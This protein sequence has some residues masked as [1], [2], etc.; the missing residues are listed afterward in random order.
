MKNALII[1][2]SLFFALAILF[3][4]NA[5]TNDQ[6]EGSPIGDTQ[7]TNLEKKNTTTEVNPEISAANLPLI[8]AKSS[9]EKYVDWGSKPMESE[10]GPADP[11]TMPFMMC[12]GPAFLDG[13]LKASSTLAA[14]G[15]IKYSASQ[16]CDDDPTTAWIEGHSDYGVGEFLELKWTPMSDGEISIL[17][18]YQSSKSVW[19]NNSR[20]KKLKVSVGGKAVCMIALTDVMGVQ[21]FKIPG[22]VT[23]IN[24]G[25]DGYQYNVDGSIRFTI[26]EVYPGLKYK[27][28][29]ISGIFSCGG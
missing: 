10:D 15:K 2:S 19:E 9:G 3:G 25:K 14:Q 4:C 22:L 21:K 27:D 16:V 17:N 6:Q 7:N 24:N 8:K 29:A 20:V 23:P 12:Q 13:E 26:A 5:N 11:W 28:T 1:F 18:G